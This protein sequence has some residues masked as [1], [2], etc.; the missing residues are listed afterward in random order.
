[1]KELL[2]ATG[3][4]GKMKEFAALF[5][6]S[7]VKL[8]SLKDFPDL[9][10]AI[11]DGRTFKENALKKAVTAFRQTGLSVIADDSGLCVDALDGRPGVLSARFAGEGC[12]DEANNLKLLQ[13]MKGVPK[14]HRSAAFRCVIAFCTH[15]GLEVVFNGELRGF[16][17]EQPSGYGGFGYDPIFMVPEY[18]KTVAELP[19]EVKNRISHRGRATED[20]RVYLRENGF[21]KSKA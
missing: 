3:N 9:A 5:A 12:G 13:E 2:I 4:S 11:E 10:P 7:G 8:F 17:L 6:G 18:G 14:E 19:I 20:L 15:E 16:I 21:M 1:M